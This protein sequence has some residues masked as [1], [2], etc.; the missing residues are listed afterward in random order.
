MNT[1]IG[2]LVLSTA[3][4]GVSLLTIVGCDNNAQAVA[5]TAPAPT[6]TVG[7][8]IDDTVI[9]S[10]VK[11]ALLADADIHSVDFKVET[12]KGDVLLSG[13]VNNQDQVDRATAAART[14]PP[15][16]YAAG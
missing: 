9:T 2:T 12:R 11:S 16:Q 15:R 10:S 5:A 8:E 13:F 7:T 6:T 1:R 14:A 3:L 4:A